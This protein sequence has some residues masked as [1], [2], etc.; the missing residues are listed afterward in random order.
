MAAPQLYEE[1]EEAFE[2]VASLLHYV[3]ILE[4]ARTEV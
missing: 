4:L 2:T 1:A 3:A